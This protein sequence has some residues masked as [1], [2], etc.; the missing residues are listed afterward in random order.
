MGRSLHKLGPAS[1][2]LST[3]SH[4]PHGSPPHCRSRDG[5]QGQADPGPAQGTRDLG[6]PTPPRLCIPAGRGLPSQVDGLEQQTQS[7]MQE[8]SRLATQFSAELAR[9]R[10]EIRQQNLLIARL[11]VRPHPYSGDRRS[12]RTRHTLTARS[13]PYS[14]SA[15]LRIK[16]TPLRP[17]L[18]FDCKSN[19]RSDQY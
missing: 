6:T 8:W 19:N 2:P 10:E 14:R 9:S 3:A 5:P 18:H 16:T 12:N 13:C 7:E 4:V 1:S 17:R 15:G 11:Q